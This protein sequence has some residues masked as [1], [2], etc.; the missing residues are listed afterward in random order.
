[1]GGYEHEFFTRRTKIV[2]TL[3][4]ASNSPEVIRQLIQAGMDVARLNFSHGSYEDHARTV[5]TLRGIAQELDSPVTILQDLQGPKIRVGQLPSGEISLQPGGQVSLVSATAYSN[6][7][8]TIP[9]D[10]PHLAD[11][12]RPGMQVLLADGAF[13]LEMVE[14]EGGAVRCRAVLV[15]V[16]VFVSGCG[17]SIALEM[18]SPGRS[19]LNVALQRA[20]LRTRQQ[21]AKQRGDEL[22]DGVHH[23]ALKSGPH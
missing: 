6:Q 16:G 20:W 14:I 2:A 18:A 23:A 15:L 3:G 8:D 12:A 1:M 5:A 7:P 11:E 13:E 4:P 10:Y 17:E 9:I 19:S 22:N 21:T